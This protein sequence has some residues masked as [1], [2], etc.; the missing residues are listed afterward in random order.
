MEQVQ[1]Y[2]DYFAMHPS[3][4]LALVFFIALGEALLVIGL[5][6]P[7]TAVLVGAGTLVGAGKLPFWPVMLA[8]ILGCVA[9][10]QLSFWAGRIFGERLRGMWPLRNYPHL[11]AKG[12]AYVREHG[13]KSIAIGRFVPGIKSVVPG[14][15]GMFGMSQV[16]FLVVNVLSG[17]VWGAMHVLPG[18]LLGQ[19]LALAGELSGRLAVVLLALVAILAIGG[20]LVRLL[21]AGL[22]P[23]RKAAQGR[24]ASWAKASSSLYVRRF[25]RVIAPENPNSVLLLMIIAAGLAAIIALVDLLTGLLIRQAVG[26]FD[27]SIF[28]LFSEL[29]SVP[30]DEL[31]VRLTMFAEEPVLYAMVAVP[32]L[33][34][35]AL[36]KWRAVAAIIATMLAAKLVG[37]LFSFGLPGPAPG[38]PR[39]DFRFP[40]SAVLMAGTAF[41]IIAAMTARG[42]SRWSQAL[43]VAS[44]AMAVVAIA[45]SRL[46]LGVNWLSDV[47]GGVLIGAILAVV[48]SVAISTI[49]L[50]RFHPWALLSTSLA[51]LVLAA[52]LNIGVNF[53]RRVERYQPFDKFSQFTQADYLADG[54]AK[55]PGQRINLIGKPAEVFVVHWLGSQ[56]SLREALARNKFKL[57]NRWGWRDLLPYLN[58]HV[59]LAELS[60]NPAVH[61]GLRAK[62]TA[63]EDDPPPGVGR[64]VLRAYLT[65]TKVDF[66]PTTPPL[67][68]Y[69]VN[70]T[71][72]GLKPNL[73]MLTLPSDTAAS[74]EEIGTIESNLMDDPAIETLASKD[75]AGHKVIILRPKS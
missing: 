14:I 59:A 71:R 26:N 9:G 42:L 51:A 7:S 54:W 10:D 37:L 70:V 19:A 31:F 18:V 46:Y 23:Y 74:A 58:P 72:E 24:V 13:G 17:I 36:R 15:A 53:D 34:M 57:W 52:G 73:G 20:W 69:V 43:I 1:P 64:L 62:I 33:W 60:P 75:A 50:G 28:N 61:E 55:L 16:Y 3:W 66:G 68:V 56:Q 21:A 11:L 39:M 45:F 48:F 40:S 22:A 32:L 47:A 30:G 63:T 25:G 4:A 2:L 27:L 65:N 41:G 38:I 6:V 44:S 29:R 5:F 35:A 8:A 49:S 67:R 12:E